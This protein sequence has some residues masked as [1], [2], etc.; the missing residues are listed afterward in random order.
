MLH[1]VRTLQGKIRSLEGDAE[2]L[3]VDHLETQR[4]ASDMC[5]AHDAA[6]DR[7]TV[8]HEQVGDG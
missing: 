2:S 6:M 5:A 8:A 4:R 3:R 1:A 7:E